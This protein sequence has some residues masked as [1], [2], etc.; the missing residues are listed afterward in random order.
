V[1]ERDREFEAGFLRGLRGLAQV[2]DDEFAARVR[3]RVDRA[4][5][6]LARGLPD[7]L[8]VS[9]LLSEIRE[10]CE[11][12]CGWSLMALQ[13]AAHHGLPAEA[14]PRLRRRLSSASALAAMADREIAEALDELPVARW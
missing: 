4:G 1:S 13:V 2:A 3:A 12:V 14:M 7:H 9:A 6:H 10:E 5:E 11:D 8:S